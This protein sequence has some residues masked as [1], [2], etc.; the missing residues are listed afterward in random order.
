MPALGLNHYNIKA[1]PELLEC[2]RDF[3]VEVLGLRVGDRPPFPFPGYW[4]YAGDRPVL[5]LVAAGGVTPGSGAGGID[6]IAFDA[7]GLESMRKLLDS[8]GVEYTFAEV[9]G[10][11]VRQLFLRDPVRNRIELQFSPP[12]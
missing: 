3:Y 4:L 5:H 7:E 9:P 1:A 8:H 12:P 11:G 2:V 10:S 6:H